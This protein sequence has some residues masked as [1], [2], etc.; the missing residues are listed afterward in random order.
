MSGT[1]HGVEWV[2]T[3]EEVVVTEECLPPEGNTSA[4]R[5]QAP[6][7][8]LSVLYWFN[9]CNVL[10]WCHSSDASFR[11]SRDAHPKVTGHCGTWRQLRR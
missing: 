6:H 7:S 8:T 11:A 3:T 9:V 2:E 4:G 10:I 5:I 1:S